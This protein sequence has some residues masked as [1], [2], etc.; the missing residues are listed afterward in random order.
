MLGDLGSYLHPQESRSPVFFHKMSHGKLHNALYNI[1]RP[2][3]SLLYPVG[4]WLTPPR[5]Q[6]SHSC[7]CKQTVDR[8]WIQIDCILADLKL[9]HPNKGLNL[10]LCTW[11]SNNHGFSA[12]SISK[13]NNE[14]TPTLWAFGQTIQ[15]HKRSNMHGFTSFGRT[16]GDM[17]S[18]CHTT[19][20]LVNPPNS[21]VNRVSSCITCSRVSLFPSIPSLENLSEKVKGS[22]S[23]D[24]FHARKLQAKYLSMRLR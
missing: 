21:I 2:T 8:Q 12:W 18:C 5:S 11:K 20:V 10:R 1:L 13:T 24:V 17:S 9:V 3:I 16:I 15:I 19:I 23:Q 7:S 22:L 6:P 14:A 4:K